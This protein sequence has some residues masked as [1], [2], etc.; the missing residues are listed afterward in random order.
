MMGHEPSGVIEKI[1]Q[2]VDSLK[3]GQRVAVLP[4]GGGPFT[5]YTN[6]GFAEYMV[7]PQKRGALMPPGIEF[8]EA[9]GEPVACLVSGL[10]RTE[11]HLADRVAIIGCGFMG[12]AMLQLVAQRGPR[13]IVAIDVRQE[14]LENALRFGADRAMLPKQIDPRDRAAEWAQIGQG[15][16]VVFEVTGTQAGLT[17]AGELVTAHGTL[18]IVGF[19]EMG[20]RTLDVRLWNLKAITVINAHERRNDYLMHCMQAGLELIAKGKLDMASLVTHTYPLDKVDI[21]FAAMRDKPQGFIKAVI[22]PQS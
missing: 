5:E 14:A 8:T 13:E 7:I 11:I 20:M 4:T 19:H 15:F 21:A 3:V 9:I 2:S 1:G 12:L 22:L 6:G 17:L 10:E 18:S 16:D